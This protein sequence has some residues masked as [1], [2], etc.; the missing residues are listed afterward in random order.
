MDLLTIQRKNA[1]LQNRWP[2]SG[3]AYDAGASATD[4]KADRINTIVKKVAAK[5]PFKNRWGGND[6]P[7]DISD[8]GQFLSTLQTLSWVLRDVGYDLTFLSKGGLHYRNTDYIG[9]SNLFDTKESKINALVAVGKEG[10]HYRIPR[11]GSS[12]RIRRFDNVTRA[13][14]PLGT[15]VDPG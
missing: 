7:I 1:G 9:Y 10:K 14:A 11:D 12:L 3:L 5:A 4:E 15:A 8:Y 2:Y 6:Y 13:I